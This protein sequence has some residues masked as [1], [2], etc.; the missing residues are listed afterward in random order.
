MPKN[1]M[2][3]LCALIWPDHFKFASYGPAFCIHLE[4]RGI[5]ILHE[6][7][8]NL[9][10]AHR[11]RLRSNWSKREMRIAAIN[12][13]QLFLCFVVGKDTDLIQKLSLQFSLSSLVVIKCI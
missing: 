11:I 9:L 3:A 1:N 5:F 2:R 13:A 7:S 12:I 4:K 6:A 8:C 10:I